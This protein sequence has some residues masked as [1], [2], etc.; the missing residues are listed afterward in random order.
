MAHIEAFAKSDQDLGPK[1]AGFR[2]LCRLFAAVSTDPDTQ[3]MLYKC[4]HQRTCLEKD[5]AVELV[6]NWLFFLPLIQGKLKIAKDSSALYLQ[7]TLDD[8]HKSRNDKGDL[9]KYC[10]LVPPQYG[11]ASEQWEKYTDICKRPLVQMFH[12]Q[13]GATQK[14]LDFLAI[15]FAL[16][17]GTSNSNFCFG[18]DQIR[19]LLQLCLQ[20]LGMPISYL[21]PEELDDR[22][23]E[24]DGQYTKLQEYL[25]VCLDQALYAVYPQQSKNLASC[26][27]AAQQVFQNEYCRIDAEEDPD[28]LVRELVDRNCS[29]E[30]LRKEWKQICRKLRVHQTSHFSGY[31]ESVYE[32]PA[33]V[34]VS[35]ETRTG[36]LY[37]DEQATLKRFIYGCQAGK[38][39]FLR[40]VALCCMASH[41]FF[42]GFIEDDTGIFSSISRKLM[43]DASAYFPLLLDCRSISTDCT[44]PV[45]EAIRQFCGTLEAQSKHLSHSQR[46]LYHQLVHQLCTQQLMEGQLLLLVD[47]WDQ[48]PDKLREALYHPDEGLHVLIVSDQCR[49]S[50]MRKMSDNYMCWKITEL[51]TEGKQNLIS[52]AAKNPNDYQQLLV[53]NRYLDLFTDT[54]A[55]LLLLLS[56][57]GDSWDSMLTGEINSQLERLD[58]SSHFVDHFFHQLARGLLENHWMDSVRNS[59]DAESYRDWDVIPGRLP[60]Q[61]LFRN[62]PFCDH[63]QANRIWEQACQDQILVCAADVPRGFRFKNPMFCYSLAADAYLEILQEKREADRSVTHSLCR[64]SP[65]HFSYVIVLLINR[66]CGTCSDDYGYRSEHVL[67][68]LHTLCQSIAGYV[69]SLTDMDDAVHCCRALADILGGQYQENLLSAQINTADFRRKGGVY[70]SRQILLRSYTYLYHATKCCHAPLVLPLPA[71]LIRPDQEELWFRRYYPQA[72]EP[73]QA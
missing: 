17:V 41:P 20:Q 45:A 39:S 38:S 25:A 6:M 30:N 46:E 18:K 65:L 48:A 29:I 37:C 10:T 67:D 2:F 71:Q 26:Q 27:Q 5:P 52:K 56:Y 3:K 44:D 7:R 21:L 19:K 33:F 23:Q 58:M 68:V 24:D 13:T 9:N 34:P 64:L 53:R 66:L 62:D 55:R 63:Q 40:I 31:L 57:D 42:N 16:S 49:K 69:L 50:E 54:P 12:K 14:F 28:G 1:S 72:F 51:T 73:N 15:S 4:A 60:S 59:L 36:V 8:L 22:P 11:S 47:N 35:P 61:S 70:H 43:F 32:V